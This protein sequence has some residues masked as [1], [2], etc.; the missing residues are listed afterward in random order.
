MNLAADRRAIRSLRV[1][2]VP[3]SHVLDLTV[4]VGPMRETL[5]RELES[6]KHGRHRP[7]VV[8]G[9]WGTGKSN[10][11]S[12]LREYCLQ[13]KIAVAYINLNGRSSAINHPQRFYHRVVAEV[14]IPGFEG[15]G[16][17]SLLEAMK[18][19]GVQDA[20]YKWASA[21][22]SRS[23]LA[24]AFHAFV[25]GHRQW[26]LQIILGTDLAWADYAYKKEKAMRRLDDL[27]TCL[28]SL[29][30]SGLMIQ[31]DELETMVQLWNVVSRR[32]AYRVLHTLSNMRNVWSAYAITEKLNQQLDS[33]RR[34]GK[35]QDLTALEFVEDY[36]KFPVM[37][38]PVIDDR[39]GGEL[40][41]KVEGLYRRVYQVPQDAHLNHVMERWRRMPFRNPRRLIRHAIDHLDQ[42][43]PVPLT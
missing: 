4:G 8:S 36:R 13:R 19:P 15:K 23:E 17:L 16:I 37:K 32:G 14:R 9:E 1:G 43:R 5:D 18:V 39:L 11:L 35:V 21:N 33:D 28:R 22:T 34:S 6:F 20:V 12:Y 42:Q 3:S 24:Q 30:Y 38:P 25:N 10:L 26:P 7:L 29:G 27:G 40:L 31:Y 2:V 41:Q